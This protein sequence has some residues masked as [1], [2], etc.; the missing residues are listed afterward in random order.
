MATSAGSAHS[1]ESSDTLGTLVAAASRDV[2]TLVRDEIALAKAELRRDVRNAVAGGGSLAVAALC[3][4][5]AL[6]MLSI[7]AMF[8][9]HA[10]GLT[11]GWSG[12]IVAG[13]YLLIAACCLL[14]ARGAFRRL[15]AIRQ[16]VVSTRIVVSSMRTRS[17]RR[18][19]S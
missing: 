13:G 8:G 15:G 18:V 4:L 7:A 10:L 16:A 14:V 12:L 2:S 6:V 9:I 1:A 5:F 19:G 3:G 17:A 11:M